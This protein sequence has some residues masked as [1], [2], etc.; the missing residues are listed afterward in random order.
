MRMPGFTAEDSLYISGRNYYVMRGPSGSHRSVLPAQLLKGCDR[1]CVRECLKTC[2]AESR[3]EL[4]PESNRACNLDCW[5][6]CCPEV[7][8]HI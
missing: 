4:F 8:E 1:R 7:A 2:S 5:F 3:N 6:K